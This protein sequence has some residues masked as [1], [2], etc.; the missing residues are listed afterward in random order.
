MYE[1]RMLFIV[2][3][4]YDTLEQLHRKYGEHIVPTSLWEDVQRTKKMI[5]G[6]DISISVLG[7]QNSGKSTF[8][9][10]LIGEE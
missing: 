8:L 4:V 2:Q 5:M 9:N 7:K 6:K 1:L 3:T 10:A